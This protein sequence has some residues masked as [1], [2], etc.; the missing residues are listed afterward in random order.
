MKAKIIGIGIAVIVAVAVVVVVFGTGAFATPYWEDET[1]FGVWQTEIVI[2][3]ADG[4]TE[5]LKII[6][7][8]WDSFTVRYFNK[9]ITYIGIKIRAVAEGSGYDGAE[10]RYTNSFG[11]L[12]KIMKGGVTLYS[13]TSTLPDGNTKQIAFNG[14]VAILQSGINIEERTDANPTLYPTGPYLVCFEPQ[15]TVQYRGYPD[16]G[17]DNPWKTASLPP[18]RS[19]FVNVDQPITGQVVVTLSSEIETRS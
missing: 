12:K 4:T 19:V 9:E 17:I 15:G 11:V 16:I 5:S 14:G 8:T 13:S 3:F 6:E 2:E 1:G 7:E 10:L 18:D